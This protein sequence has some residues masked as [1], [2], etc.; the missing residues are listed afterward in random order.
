MTL[1]F[2]IAT[3]GTAVP[4]AT[5]TDGDYAGGGYAGDDHGVPGGT[6]DY[7]LGYDANGWDTQGF[8]SPAAGYLDN[9]ETAQLTLGVRPAHRRENG[10]GGSHAR[11]AG[12]AGQQ[13]GQPNWVPDAAGSTGPWLPDQPRAARAARRGRR[14]KPGRRPR[15]P[16]ARTA[17]RGP[18]V[19]VKGSWWR[20]WTLAEGPGR[21]AR[22]HRRVH[23]AGRHRGRRGLRGDAGP[24]RGD[25]RHRLRADHRLLQ[26]RHPDRAV[27]HH[28][29]GS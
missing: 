16:G 7:D 4:G 2:G 10:R 11:T 20:H 29:P 24:H 1:T 8:R 18:K 6:V 19:K 13:A 17:R 5:G 23:H 26:Q 14:A 9:H 3:A 15:R 25:G 21:A 22:P 27:R 28:Q 12:R